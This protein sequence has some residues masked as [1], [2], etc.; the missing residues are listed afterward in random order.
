LHEKAFLAMEKALALVSVA[1][2]VDAI[3]N[4]RFTSTP[5]VG[6]VDFLCRNPRNTIR[7][8]SELSR[9]TPSLR[10]TK[11]GRPSTPYGAAFSR[12]REKEKPAFP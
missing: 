6:V 5:A 4:G 11:G 10:M 2:S 9:Q 7:A 8:I 3:R 12:K 1:T